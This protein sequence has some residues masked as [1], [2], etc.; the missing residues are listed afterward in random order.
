M[1][2]EVDTSARKPDCVV[3][4]TNVWRS[5]LLLKAPIGVSL[6][7]TLHKQGGFIGLPEVVERELKKQVV[8]HGIEASQELEKWSRIVSTLMD[9][10][11]LPDLPTSEA[12]ERK[13]NERLEELAPILVR[14]PFTPEH[15]SAALD[16]V[17]EELPPNRPRNQQ[18]KDS[19]IWQAVLNL[20]SEYS[21][22]FVTNDRGFLLDRNDPAKGLTDN[23]LEDCRRLLSKRHHV[24]RALI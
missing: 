2:T 12:L 3:I 9:S 7:Y 17:I 20:A 5:S 6:V 23:L 19:A 18:F 21:L 11:H 4:D 8:L 24:R 15:A 1:N 13:V 14:V 10:L 22:H 16:M